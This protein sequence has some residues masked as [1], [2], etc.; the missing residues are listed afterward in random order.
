MKPLIE[1]EELIRL[2]VKEKKSTREIANLKNCAQS[3]V[4]KYLKT[5]NIPT[6]T[7][8]EAVKIANPGF[9]NSIEEINIEDII[10]KIQIESYKPIKR[11]NI[12]ISLPIE[13][14]TKE[15]KDCVLTLVISDTHFGDSNVLLYSYWST[16]DNLLEILKIIKK[17]LNIKSF[18][19]VLNGDIVSGREVYR[20]QIFRNLL[21]RGHWQVFLA[22]KI[23]KDTFSKIEEIVPINKIFL[24]RGTHESLEENY[25]LYLKR[26]LTNSKYLSH[27]GII[28]IGDPIGKYNILFTHGKGRSEYYPV[29]YE[30]I[31]EIWKSIPQFLSGNIIIERTC[32]GHS[33]WLTTNLEL[34]GVCID[35]TGGFQKWE[36]SIH[37]RP[38]GMILYLFYNNET[39]SI[40]I[41]PNREIEIKEKND[42]ALEYKNMKLYGQILLKHVKEIEKV[43]V[44]NS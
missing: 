30:Q 35:I 7:I 39:V 32:I 15:E 24:I 19:I 5:Y 18:K 44:E 31:R 9:H 1:K 42:P 11:K 14:F 2:Y 25:I 4:L 26:T 38:C 29:S 16:I 10:D 40:P 34:E 33:H 8:S 37:Q 27:A 3:T 13:F 12:W 22:E 20:Y 28:N 36:Y 23:L 43:E 21:S 41:K 17:N 6:R